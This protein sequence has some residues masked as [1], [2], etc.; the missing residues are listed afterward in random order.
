M[1]DIQRSACN[2]QP[3]TP[4]AGEARGTRHLFLLEPTSI[5][6]ESTRD[7][8]RSQGEEPEVSEESPMTFG[9]P[10]IRCTGQPTKTG[11]RTLD[12]QR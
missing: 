10:T 12:I 6:L 2:A 9:S 1:S 7:A 3:V 5:G 11:N 8:R 4:A